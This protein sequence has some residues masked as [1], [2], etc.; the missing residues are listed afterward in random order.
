MPWNTSI[1]PNRSIVPSVDTMS[2]QNRIGWEVK[3]SSV[4][5]IAA[6]RLAVSLLRDRYAS[7]AVPA[8]NAHISSRAACNEA[9]KSS[10]NG[11][12]TSLIRTCPP[13]R[14]R[15]YGT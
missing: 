5:P 14:K 12:V 7:I 9:I 10:E 3:T 8:K 13:T 1:I 15:L 11:R 6:Q 2:W 4:A